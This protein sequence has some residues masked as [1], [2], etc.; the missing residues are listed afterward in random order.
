MSKTSGALTKYN[1]YVYIII[2]K[3][4]TKKKIFKIDGSFRIK[5]VKFTA[6]RKPVSAQYLQ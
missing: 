5:A 4:K 1:I 3:M 6:E 2:T